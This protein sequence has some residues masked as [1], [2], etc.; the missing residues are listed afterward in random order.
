MYAFE[1]AFLRRL[2]AIRLDEMSLV[3][4]GAYVRAGAV[5]IAQF[6]P[7]FMSLV[8]FIV[9]AAT[10][11]DLTPENV[12]SA[13]VLFN[14][15]RF[16]LMQ[17]PFVGG[18]LADALVSKRRIEE[19]LLSDEIS[20][21]PE[22]VHDSKHAVRIDK[23][24]FTW[25]TVLQD[26]VDDERDKA[27]GKGKGK[28]KD[29]GGEEEDKD[30]G[31]VGLLSRLFGGAKKN[32]RSWKGRV[33]DDKGGAESLLGNLEGDQSQQPNASV[34]A[35]IDDKGDQASAA[36]PSALRDVNVEVPHGSLTVIVGAVGSGKSSL[37]S[38]ILG[39]MKRRSGRVALC[40]SLGYCHQ[41]A[42]IQNATLRDNVLFGLAYDEQR[43]NQVIKGRCT[44]IHHTLAHWPH[45]GSPCAGASGGGGVGG[46]GGGRACRLV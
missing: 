38:G 7:I 27:K 20:D 17:V 37:L 1:N 19:F 12:F 3:R 43:Y 31:K 16:P 40:G 46:G 22:Q 15:L 11:G 44:F 13:L 26:K 8:A 34:A 23:G 29:G 39:E 32:K 5:T 10:G 2:T 41:S 35:H 4:H 21:Q 14:L 24:E 6:G 45:W 9:L 42:W 25:E 36:A 33:K 28:G 18:M 30:A